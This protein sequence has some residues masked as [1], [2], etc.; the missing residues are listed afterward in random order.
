MIKLA[1]ILN[2]FVFD[3]FELFKQE[4]VLFIDRLSEN[5]ND[6]NIC[7]S[8]NVMSS[9]HHRGGRHHLVLAL[10]FLWSFTTV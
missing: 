9:S 3:I 6:R 7:F 1:L 2:T 10:L 8:P 5:S 4:G